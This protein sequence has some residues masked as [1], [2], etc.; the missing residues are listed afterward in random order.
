MAIYIAVKNY[1]SVS[2]FR[3][4]GGTESTW[5]R[6]RHFTQRQAAKLC[7]A[8]IQPLFLGVA[9]SVVI[10]IA[11]VGTLVEPK[12]EIFEHLTREIESIGLTPF[13]ECRFWTTGIF[14][15]KTAILCARTHVV[16]V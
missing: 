8:G 9:I 2:T 15:A 1:H 12:P 14:V 16:S 4:S 10:F 7:I 11:E 5:H 3:I 6:G 13:R